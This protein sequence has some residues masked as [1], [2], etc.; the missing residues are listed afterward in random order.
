MKPGRSRPRPRTTAPQRRPRETAPRPQQPVPKKVEPSPSPQESRSPEPPTNASPPPR[1]LDPHEVLAVEKGADED[2]I[3]DA[4][5]DFMDRYSEDA[6]KDI[7]EGELD[8]RCRE[9]T[10][11]FETLRL[12]CASPIVYGQARSV[13]Q[14]RELVHQF[15]IAVNA[16]R[17]ELLAVG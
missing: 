16:A 15:V 6:V 3:E 17:D 13:D 8:Q 7:D 12:T 4:Y 11:R 5:W 2:A 9:L 14:K 10:D 1:A